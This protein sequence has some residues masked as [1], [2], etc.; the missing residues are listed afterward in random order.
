M[1]LPQV[2][3]RKLKMITYLLVCKNYDLKC[4]KNKKTDEKF[5]ASIKFEFFQV[6]LKL[7]FRITAYDLTY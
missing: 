6:Q 3:L 4:K 5:I 7:R 1:I 2:N